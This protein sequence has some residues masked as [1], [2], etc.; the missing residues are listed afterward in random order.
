MTNEEVK[1]EAKKNDVRF[2]LI[3]MQC[4][5]NRKELMQHY[6]IA[7]KTLAEYYVVCEDKFFEGQ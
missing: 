1:I 6:E 7:C 4:A 3:K 5:E 2:A